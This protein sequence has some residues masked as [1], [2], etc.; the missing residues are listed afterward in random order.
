MEERKDVVWYEWKYKISN[1]WKVKSLSRLVLS[2]K[3]SNF[4]HKWCLLK[5]CDDLYG[6]KQVAL[7]RKT[8]KVHRLVAEAF[9]PNP[10]NKPRINHKNAI[11]DDNRVENLERCIPIE[12]INHCI[13]MWRFVN[14]PSRL[15]KFWEN[16]WANKNYKK[17]LT[18]LE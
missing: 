18:W 6:Y 4:R 2:N 1:L 3:R 17:H 5:L 9:I 7:C 10:D 16:H 13:N 11:R 12:N 14:P 15:W 8:Y